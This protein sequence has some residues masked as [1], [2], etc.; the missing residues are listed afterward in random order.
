MKLINIKKET[1]NK[2]LNLYTLELTNKVGKRKD[3]YVASRRE[4]EELACVTKDHKRADGI[5]ILPVTKDGEIVVIKQY[6]PALG[7]NVFELPAGLIEKGENIEE[8]AY[9]ELYEETGLKGLS[10]EVI[11]KP[12]YVSSGM[13]D[14]SIVTVKV[15]AEGTTTNEHAEEDEEIEIFKFKKE[16]I[17]NLVKNENIGARDALVMML[18]ANGGC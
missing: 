5:L 17:D 11:L 8:A 1:N 7:D 6:R 9:R 3:Y 16:E 4:Q 10:C 15:L 2:F 12:S 18:F 13:T 14:E